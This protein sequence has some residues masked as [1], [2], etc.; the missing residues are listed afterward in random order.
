MMLIKVLLFA[1]LLLLSRSVKVQ[2][3]YEPSSWQA[4]RKFKISQ[5]EAL[6]PTIYGLDIIVDDWDGVVSK[7]IQ[8]RGHWQP[9][10]VRAMSKFVKEGSS[11]L[12]IGAHVGLQAIVLAE[13]VGP[14]GKLY[15]F[16]PTELTYQILVKN[17]YLNQLEEITTVYKMGA[18][19]KLSVGIS[20]IRLANTGGSQ[21]KTANFTKKIS[22]DVTYEQVIL[23]RADKILPK[24]AVIDF[25]LI[26]T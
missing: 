21:I 6:V 1:V 16:E 14:K 5:R 26:D 7:E 15:I 2:C 8:N 11:I 9:R 23:D 24:A 10:N 22:P 20:E 13:K 3:E 12:N 17:I 4:Q 19:D 18:S 25:A